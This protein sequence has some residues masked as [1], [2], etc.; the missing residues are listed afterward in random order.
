MATVVLDNR[1]ARREHAV[2][3]IA[4]LENGD[5]TWLG[6][7]SVAT[8]RVEAGS[9]C[10]TPLSPDDVPQPDGLL[11]VLREC[12]GQT[13]L[14]AKGYLVGS[15]EIVVEVAASSA[16]LDVQEKLACYRRAGVREY[17]V[18]RT[19]DEAVDWWAREEDEYRPL[20]VGADGL[21]RSRTFPGLWLNPQALVAQDGKKVLAV[22][23]EGLASA[24]HETFVADL[25]R[26]VARGSTGAG[27]R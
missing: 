17:L 6:T 24:D 27:G 10:T 14:D 4:P 5:H 12:G 1:I 26:R 20:P 19:E 23:G 13:H 15:P 25:E 18:W 2:R 21:L 11:R 7:Y 8:P 3:G 22:L 16:S 9:N